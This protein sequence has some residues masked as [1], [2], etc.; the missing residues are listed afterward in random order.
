MEDF[1]NGNRCVWDDDENERFAGKVFEGN[2]RRFKLSNE[3][4]IVIHA[5][6]LI[7]LFNFIG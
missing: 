6:A 4:R 2:G 5:Y 7:Y 3:E 1:I